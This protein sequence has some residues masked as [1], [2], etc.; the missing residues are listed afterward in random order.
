MK[1]LIAGGSGFVGR[2]VVE[3]LCGSGDAV[4]NVDI[5]PP[6][7]A[8]PG[9]TVVTA[10]LTTSTGVAAA[11][12]A[13]AGAG[14]IVWLA[15]AIRHVTAVDSSAAL[16]LALMVEAPVRLL[17]A[18]PS[19]PQAFV[20]MS[21]VQVYGRPVSLP[22]DEDHPTEPFNAY[23]VA[24]LC[25]EHVLRI[26][27]AAR[28]TAFTAL[29]AAFIYGPGQHAANVIPRF[30]ERVRRGEPPILNG[31][32]RDVRDDIYVGDVARAVDL[33]LRIRPR[34]AFNVASGR[35]HTLRE[36]AEAACRLGPR[37]LAPQHDERPSGWIDRWYAIDR[38]RSGFGFEA[39]TA[40]AD[41][42]RAQWDALGRG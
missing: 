8:V 3:R 25:A 34:G 18:L 7:A 38:A 27:C 36:V 39:E 23:G 28:G 37:R 12:E 15:A 6:A 26:A 32:G 17:N 42:L 24:K 31:P 1:H 33:A 30:L 19:P 21:S 4:L 20:A 11:A 10:D 29:R 13:G 2:H 5:R 41:G 9:E 16:D 22:V 40:F 35:P 14:A